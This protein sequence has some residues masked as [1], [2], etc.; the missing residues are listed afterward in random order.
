M[1]ERYRVEL[2]NNIEMLP[3]NTRAKEG[4]FSDDEIF[5]L[6]DDV[7]IILD[8]LRK[9]GF[10]LPAIEAVN[11]VRGEYQ[12]VLGCSIIN[13]PLYLHQRKRYTTNVDERNIRTEN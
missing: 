12:R 10:A 4:K 13:P 1:T 9:E 3:L 8:L 7:P 2:T 5:G 6:T 11:A